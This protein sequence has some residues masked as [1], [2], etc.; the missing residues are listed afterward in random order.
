MWRSGNF[1]TV[2]ISGPREFRDP[3][4]REPRSRDGSRG[5]EIWSRSGPEVVP[6]SPTGFDTSAGCPT[7]RFSRFW[8]N[9]I[10]RPLRA[11][12]GSSGRPARHIARRDPLRALQSADFG[13]ATLP[14]APPGAPPPAR[15]TAD[16]R[17]DYDTHCYPAP[18][19]PS[20][21]RRGHRIIAPLVDAR[22]RRPAH[23]GLSTSLGP[24]RRPDDPPARAPA[25]PAPSAPSPETGRGRWRC[26]DFDR[27][28]RADPDR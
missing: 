13:T 8:H 27:A 11:P 10:F 3:T 18:R 5:P 25:S 15:A 12:P 4:G 24:E 9:P 26:A 6:K 20:T 2:A 28:G 7:D 14:R 16:A 1:G 22:G 23:A 21:R 19:R 17:G